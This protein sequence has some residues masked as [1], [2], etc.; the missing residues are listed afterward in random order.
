M[1]AVKRRIPDWI[2][3]QI[4]SGKTY[5]MVKDVISGLH[6]HT[7]CMEARCPNIG[8]CFRCGTATFLI[9]GD[10]CTRN[11][12]YCSVKKGVPDVPD[13]TEPRRI[14]EAVRLLGLKYVVITS[15]TRDDLEDG[16]A[17]VFAETIRE[18]KKD[19][20]ETRVEVLVP[21][22][23]NSLSLSLERVLGAHPDVVNHNI[24]VVRSHYTTLRPLGDYGE[25]LKLIETVSRKGVPAKSGLMIGFGESMEEIHSTLG[26]LRS[27]G[28]SMVTIGQ[29]LQSDPGGHQVKKFFTPEEFHEIRVYAEDLGFLSVQSGPMVRSSY[30]AGMMTDRLRAR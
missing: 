12:R 7:I 6:L 21:D 28:C 18:I 17:S 19:S 24:E 15:V 5:H 9:L 20:G 1:G 23:K 3:F 16:G 22:F 29:Y 30:H 11:C 25:S 14:A 8:E 26:D 13:L 27:A 4:P 2:K 10:I